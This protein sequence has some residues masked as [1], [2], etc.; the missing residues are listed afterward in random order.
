MVAQA[1]GLLVV[2]AVDGVGELM[3]ELLELGHGTTGLGLLAFREHASMGTWLAIHLGFV[4]ALF[5]TMPYG[6]FVHGLYRLVA[7]VRYHLERR[8]PVPGIAAE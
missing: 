3:A 8:R 2:L 7:L 4:L 5:L 1:G 6:K